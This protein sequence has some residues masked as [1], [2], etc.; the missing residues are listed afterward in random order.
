MTDHDI[1]AGLRQQLR[2]NEVGSLFADPTDCVAITVDLNA[3]L[4]AAIERLTP[5]VGNPGSAGS[6]CHYCGCKVDAAGP[7]HTQTCRYARTINPDIDADE[8]RG[9][10]PP[11]FVG[12]GFCSAHQQP[13]PECRICNPAL[14]PRP[15]TPSETRQH[16]D[17]EPAPSALTQARRR[18]RHPAPRPRRAGAGARPYGQDR[19]PGGR[20]DGRG[21]GASVRRPHRRARPAR[22][23]ACGTTL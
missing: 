5:V 13:D 23:A 10:V 3:T 2:F 8:C 6:E 17:G 1:I 14:T 9:L 15:L 16:L 20:V 11:P 19:S 22:R 7:H 21:F 4:R 18:T 12:T